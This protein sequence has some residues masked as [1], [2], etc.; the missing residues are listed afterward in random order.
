MPN[1][2]ERALAKARSEIFSSLTLI[3]GLLTNLY[4]WFIVGCTSIGMYALAML[5]VAWILHVNPWITIITPL[6]PF[7]ATWYVI[8]RK[9]VQNYVALL[10][11]QGRIWD[12]DKALADYVELV[13]EQKG[14]RER[15]HG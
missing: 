12:T 11:S 15:Q 10:L 4:F 1:G 5:W 9:R 7:T 13:R 3:I 14:R 2:F 8:M 6:V